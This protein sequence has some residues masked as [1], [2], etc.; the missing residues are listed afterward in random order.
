M[1]PVRRAPPTRTATRSHLF[2]S[3]SGGA[4]AARS[5]RLAALAHGSAPG[6]SRKMIDVDGR[7]VGIGL[8]LRLPEY[9]LCTACIAWACHNYGQDGR[10][11]CRYQQD[12]HR[13]QTDQSASAKQ[14]GADRHDLPNPSCGRSKARQRGRDEHQSQVPPGDARVPLRAHHFHVDP[15]EDQRQKHGCGG[16]PTRSERG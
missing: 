1:R 9:S 6:H 7:G 14:K 13:E 16:E 10:H 5:A 15:G 2:R 8:L 11:D 4:A 12:P 3:R